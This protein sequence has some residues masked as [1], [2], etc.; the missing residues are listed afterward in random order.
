MSEEDRVWREG[1]PLWNWGQDESVPTYKWTQIPK[2]EVVRRLNSIATLQA[3]IAALQS[4][5]A[6]VKAEQDA[7]FKEAHFLATAIHRKHYH[8]VTQWKP[9][10][11]TAGL[12]SQID[13]MAAGLSLDLA[14]AREEIARARAKLIREWTGMGW[15]KEV[16]I[17]NAT[18]RYAR[19]IAHKGEEG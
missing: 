7:V 15:D 18:E 16:A 1:D 19:E 8:E 2:L 17:A 3:E 10:D 9:L 11:Y 14:A 5:L 6:A 4:D 13:N 12:I